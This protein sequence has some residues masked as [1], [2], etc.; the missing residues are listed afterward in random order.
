MTLFSTV[1]IDRK[2]LQGPRPRNELQV[3]NDY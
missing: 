1:N 2:I 3:I